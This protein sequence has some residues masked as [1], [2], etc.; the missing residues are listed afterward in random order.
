MIGKMVNDMDFLVQTKES[1]N[2]YY[3]QYR[4]EWCRKSGLPMYQRADF[5]TVEREG[6]YTKSRAKREKVDIDSTKVVG[7]YRRPNGYVPLFKRRG[8]V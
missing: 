2:S 6:F 1:Y 8:N 3:K 5:E 4:A 7:W